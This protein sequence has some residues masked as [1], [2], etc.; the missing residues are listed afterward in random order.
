MKPTCFHKI[1]FQQF[2][3]GLGIFCLFLSACATLPDHQASTPLPLPSATS[4]SLA[5]TPV[6]MIKYNYSYI[7]ASSFQELARLSP[8][9]VIGQVTEIGGVINARLDVNEDKRATPYFSI[10]QIYKFQIESHLK[11]GEDIPDG[12][13]IDILIVEGMIA[14]PTASIT[15]A[16]ID[17]QRAQQGCH[18]RCQPMYVG[19]RY[20]LFLDLVHGYPPETQYYSGSRHPWMFPLTNPDYVLANDPWD[21]VDQ[22]FPGQPLADI[23]W[24][25]ENPDVPYVRPT[26]TPF[27]ITPNPMP[28]PGLYPPPTRPYPYPDP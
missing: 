19:T 17:Q 10:G 9:I 14:A 20:L 5:S 8:L 12:A 1:N 15:Q 16:D 18:P 21:S 3:A 2:L 4:T 25:I 27:T 24:Q 22:Y 11:G 26:P 6:Q 7:T 28:N 13:I 23:L